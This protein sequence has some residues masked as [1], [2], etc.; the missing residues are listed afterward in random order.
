MNKGSVDRAEVGLHNGGLIESVQGNLVV[1]ELIELLILISN[2]REN[3]R[4]LFYEKWILPE[5]SFA[6]VFRRR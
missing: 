1:N 2:S 6:Y 4:P 3:T 5:T